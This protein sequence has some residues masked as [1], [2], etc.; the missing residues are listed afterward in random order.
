[1]EKAL[2]ASNGIMKGIKDKKLVI[3]DIET[4]GL[5]C[6]EDG[7]EPAHILRVDAIKIENGVLK[8]S[9]SSLVSCS[10]YINKHVS[11]LTGISNKT[12]KNA[13]KIKTVLTQL[14]EF[15]Y[16]YEVYARNS[17]FVNK[18]LSYYGDKKGVSIDLAKANDSDEIAKTLNYAYVKELL[19]AYKIDQEQAEPIIFA[20][21]LIKMANEKQL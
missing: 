17:E 2:N 3:I 6:G 20:N 1:M 13:P 16:G 4:S 21:L 10:K 11:A 14:K 9:F 12:L 19:S 5:C 15:T 8:E 7:N 18:F